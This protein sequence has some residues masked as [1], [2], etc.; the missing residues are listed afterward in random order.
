MDK[1][2]HS[3]RTIF[4][5]TLLSRHIA[6]MVA[7][8]ALSTGTSAHAVNWEGTLPLTGDGNITITENEPS[9][10]VIRVTGTSSTIS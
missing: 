9:N 1:S 7:L 10:N 2:L 8:L 5:K 4:R 3:S 6:F